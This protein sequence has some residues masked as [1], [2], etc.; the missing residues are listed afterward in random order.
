VDA[1]PTSEQYDMLLPGESDAV[2]RQR[3]DDIDLWIDVYSELIRFKDALLQEIAKQKGQVRDAGQLEI[4][5]D[6]TILLREHA[7]LERRRAF[8][9]AEKDRKQ[10]A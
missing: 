10:K 9:R 3:M 1:D 4:S 7:R 6:E 5:H 8:W 2:R